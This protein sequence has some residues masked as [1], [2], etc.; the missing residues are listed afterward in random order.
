MEGSV[1]KGREGRFWKEGSVMK[2]QLG[3]VG[4]E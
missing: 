3:R 4:K 1:K 2:G